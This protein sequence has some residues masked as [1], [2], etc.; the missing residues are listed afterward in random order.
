M[1]ALTKKELDESMAAH[2]AYLD[3]IGA[4]A[5]D[6]PTANVSAHDANHTS[7]AAERKAWEADHPGRA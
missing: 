2:R 6:A 3:K 1:A 7:L 4:P 5:S